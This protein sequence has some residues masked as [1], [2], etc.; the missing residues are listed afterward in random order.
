MSDDKARDIINRGDRARQLLDDD[1]FREACAKLE[2]DLI[3]GWKARP[4]EDQ[5]G[6]ERLWHGVNML[7]KIVETLRAYATT[8]RHERGRIEGLA[9]GQ[10]PTH[11]R[12][13]A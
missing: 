2:V 8:G 1:V 13:V 4:V 12:P 6:R 5:F 11:L 3:E 9:S 10:P 7:N